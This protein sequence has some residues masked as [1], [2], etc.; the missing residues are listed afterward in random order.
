MRIVFYGDSLTEGKPGAA[1]YPIVSN[2][3]VEHTLLNFGKGGDTVRS[4][5]ERIVRLNP[6]DADLAFVW[7]GVNDVFAQLSWTY[8]LMKRLLNQPWTAD[9]EAFGRRYRALLDTL[10]AR[11]GRIV[12]V[13]PLC[14][15]EDA[16]NP[17]NLKL[18]LL[19]ETI[20]KVTSDYPNV[21]YLDLRSVFFDRLAGLPIS[22]FL[23]DCPLLM[24]LGLL[25][26]GS[27]RAVDRLAAQRGLHL[28][29][30]GV[31]LNSAG[32]E[33]AANALLMRVHHDGMQP[34]RDN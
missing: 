32:A 28:T 21:E 30:D 27:A 19:A 3:L 23:P 6:P 15:G 7:V 8:R 16:N 25:K 26:Q 14:I 1:F 29:V 4:L 9:P 33:L 2:Q 24:L 12:T 13:S 17:W 10:S 18:S 31:H 22:G 20:E 5:H 11:A 34:T